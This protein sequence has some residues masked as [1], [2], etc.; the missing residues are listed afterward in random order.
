MTWAKI[1][2][3]YL[4]GSSGTD[5]HLTRVA[6][7]SILRPRNASQL[8]HHMHSLSYNMALHVTVTVTMVWEVC[9][10]LLRLGTLV[11]NFLPPPSTPQK[12]P[13]QT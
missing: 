10:R 9:H 7:A 1:K 5:A 3:T 12:M 4:L 8:P 6:A 13:W 11:A 2:H